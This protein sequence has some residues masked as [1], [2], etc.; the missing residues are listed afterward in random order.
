VVK[1]I[2]Q[3]AASP[4][5]IDGSMAFARICPRLIHA[6]LGGPSSDHIPNGISISSTTFAQPTARSR[7]TLHNGPPFPP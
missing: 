1:A 4:P 7:Y 2:G 3:Q 5:H 6:A